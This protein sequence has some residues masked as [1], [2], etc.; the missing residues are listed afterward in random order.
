MLPANKHLDPIVGVDIHIVLIPTPAGPVPTPLPHPFVGMVMDP[1][2]YIPIVGATV[3][4]NKIPRGNST[5]AGMLGTKIHIPL[6]GPHQMAATIGHDSAN[7]FGSSR[8]VCEGSYMSASGF[9]VMSCNDIGLP[10]TATPGKKMKPKPGLYLP[11]SATIPIPSGPPVIVG[12]PYVPDLMAMIMSLVMSYGMGSLMKGAGKGLK[13]AGASIKKGLTKVNHKVLKKFKCTKGLSKKFCKMGFEPVD[14][15]TGRMVYEGED[16]RIPGVIPLTWERNWYS[17][18]DYEGMMGHGVHSNYDLALYM[19]EADQVIVMRLA[20]GRLA[21]FPYLIAEGDSYFEREEKLTF[22]CVDRNTYTVKDHNTE[23]T[24]TFKRFSAELYQLESQSNDDGFSLQFFYNAAGGIEQIIDTA[25]RRIDF[26]L[27]SE[28][29]IIAIT[30]VH[31][32]SKRFFVGYSYNKEGDLIGIT[33]ALDETTVIEYENHLMVKKTDRNGQAFYWE[34]EGKQ[35]G[36]RC[37]KTW[38]DGGILAGTIEYGKGENLVTNSLGEESIYYFNSDNLC[39]QVTNPEGGHIF[40]EYTE[41]MEFYRDI[42]EEGN[43]TGYTYDSRGNLTGLHQPDGSET[44]FLYDELDRLMLSKSPG[45]SSTVRTYKDGR[46]HATVDSNGTTTTFTYN[47][48]GLINKIIDDAGNETR[49]EYDTDHNLTKIILPNE[50]ITSWDYD[51]WGNCIQ[52]SNSEQHKQQFSYDVLGR[53]SKVQLADKNLIK[54]SYNAYDEVIKTIDSKKKQL[55]FEYTPLGNLKMREEN[56]TK[57]HFK[58]STE[59]QLLAIV[60]EHKEYYRFGRNKKGEIINETG[61]DGLRR[62]FARDRAGKVLKVQRPANRFTEYEYD[63]NG[64]I[65]RTEHSDGSW[66]TYSYNKDDQLIEAVNQNSKVQLNRDEGG[67]VISEN[68]DE[69]LVESTYDGFG[70]RIHI[71]SSLGA[72]I[73]F[74]R[75]ALGFVNQVKATVNTDDEDQTWTARMR[76]NSIGMEVERSLPGGITNHMEYDFAGRPIQHKVNRANRALRHRSYIWNANDQLR[77]MVNELSSGTVSYTHD[78]FGNLASARYENQQFDYKLPDEVGNL[79]RDKNQSDRKYGP[80]GQLLEANGNKYKYD[81]EG[82]LITKITD[83]GNWEYKWYGNGMLR[84]V[85]KPDGKEISFEYDAL[86]RRTAKIVTS[87]MRIEDSEITRWVWNGNV[88]LHEWK[89]YLKDRPQWVVDE[90]GMI[91]MDKKEPLGFEQQP[92]AEVPEDEP[93]ESPNRKG[94]ITWVFDEGSFKPAAKIIDGEHFSIITDYLGTPVEMYNSKGEKTWEVEYD[95]YGKVRKLVKGSLND[96]PFRYQ[97]QYE[98]VETGLYYNRFRYYSSDE[99]VY[100]CQDPFGLAGDNPNMYGYVFDVNQE[101]DVFGLLTYNTMPGI[102]N[103]QKHHI[104]PQ[105]LK[106][107]AAI[108]KS[109]MNIHD[110]KNV[111]YLPKKAGIDPNQN[112]AVHNGPHPKYT[113]AV[114]AD[115]DNIA[116]LGKKNKWSQAKYKAEVDKVIKKYDK[117][118]STGKIKC[119]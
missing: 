41:N 49:L 24:N 102:P 95:I 20:D 96:C 21:Y 45:G 61:F 35:T 32:G 5:T 78:A 48:I 54:L 76:Y 22:T 88:P 85:D 13:K 60:N 53:V 28:K 27:D 84:S 74:E 15:I 93:K 70:N 14:L 104:I 66:E 11:S 116:K 57:V 29:R 1:M 42:D 8:V 51:A 2:D 117:K 63:I 73:Q 112:L 83:K 17:D 50:G 100:I 92:L 79:Y 99:G 114:G 72:D 36:A 52:T 56:G 91:V 97:G 82:N 18:S 113:S 64:R 25:G 65:T 4:V 103:Y 119:K 12:G 111:K 59:E 67:K 62:D 38:G 98:D 46:L 80:G 44:T 31:E 33:D 7:F 55:S 115:L 71:K 43:T 3:L 40:H 16:F 105:Q 81:P 6:G 89:Y 108:Q 118:L 19:E 39:T 26:A 34:Y 10:L 47:K 106:G 37:T 69:H 86:G 68:Q 110:S 101:V 107:H 109:G 30:G 77:K 9:M 23:L 87:R 90:E 94:F 58:Y 75:N